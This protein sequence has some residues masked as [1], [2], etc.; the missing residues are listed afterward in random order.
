MAGVLTY[1]CVVYVRYNSDHLALPFHAYTGILNIF[2]EK[3]PFLV[4]A[5]VQRL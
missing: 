2:V 3:T 5:W 1:S 4:L